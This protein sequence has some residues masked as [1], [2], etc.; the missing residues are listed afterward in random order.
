M[1]EENLNPN[2]NN[3]VP[4]DQCPPAGQCLAQNFR[5]RQA[6]GQYG[7]TPLEDKKRSRQASTA[8]HTQKYSKVNVSKALRSN[9]IAALGDFATNEGVNGKN[10][11]EKSTTDLLV[12]LL[13]HVRLDDGV[14]FE[15]DPA[16]EYEITMVCN[17]VLFFCLFVLKFLRF[18][19]KR[20]EA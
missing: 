5:P 20:Q 2:T 7:F 6:N 16:N 1:V 4:E 14:C 17:S 12:F 3:Q 18:S 8:K 15:V 9:L 11:T 10:R 13:E 19:D